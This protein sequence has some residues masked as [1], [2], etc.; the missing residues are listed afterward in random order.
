MAKN[1]TTSAIVNGI[2]KIT[3]TVGVVSAAAILPNL[4]KIL[5]KPTSDYLRKLDRES[6]EREIDRLVTYAL[7]EHLITGH[8]QHGIELTKKGR[9][10][11]KKVAYDKLTIVSPEKWDHSWRL[12]LFDIPNEL[13]ANRRLLT[14]KIRRL[15]FQ[16]LQQSVWIYPYACRDEIAL[17]ADTYSV[18]KYVTYLEVHHIDHE[19]K[20]QKRFSHLNVK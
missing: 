14:T 6:Q 5:D 3:V 4:L 16:P 2:L 1:E 15:G 20:L 11:L 10:R 7:R 19:E 13:S 9:A 8:Y 18:A 12:V 17:V